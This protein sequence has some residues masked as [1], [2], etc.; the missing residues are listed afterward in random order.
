M[1]EKAVIAYRDAQTGGHEVKKGEQNFGR[2]NSAAIDVKGA[3]D[4]ACQGGNHK[5]GYIVPLDLPDG[6]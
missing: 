6:R 5:E 4:E 1:S 2:R 3:A